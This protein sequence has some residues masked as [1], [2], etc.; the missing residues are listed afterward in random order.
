MRNTF[1]ANA[2]NVEKKWYI[3]DA[4]EMGPGR[5]AAP[6]AAI[7]RGKHKPS[8]T[9]HV[10]C[11]DKVII[12]NAEKIKFTGNKLADKKYYRHTGH[13]GGLKEEAAGKLLERK[14]ERILELAIKGM[15]PKTKLGREMY[16][17]LYVYA[18]A[19]HEQVAQKPEELS[20]DPST[21]FVK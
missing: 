2:A 15:L 17:N 19:E 9:P 4:T 14:P 6:V 5:L 18:G 1:M 8:F 11:G 7:L 3:V 21:W 20:Q 10:D 16:R 13:P 12:I